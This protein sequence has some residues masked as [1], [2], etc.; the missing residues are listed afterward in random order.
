MVPSHPFHGDPSPGN[1]NSESSHHHSLLPF[2]IVLLQ[3]YVLLQLFFILFLM[4]PI[5]YYAV[6][7]LLELIFTQYRQ[8][9]SLLLRVTVSHLFRLLIFHCVNIP[10]IEHV[11]VSVH[12]L[13]AYPS[14][15][16]VN[17]SVP[18]FCTTKTAR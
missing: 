1:P 3:V 10:C 8:D 13:T 2:H 15:S 16:Y 12:I 9:S 11:P 7:N 14:L 18:P 6:C 4:L 17:L 5:G